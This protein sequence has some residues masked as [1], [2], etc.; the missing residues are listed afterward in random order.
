MQ[1]EASALAREPGGALADTA[2]V[3]DEGASGRGFENPGVKRTQTP[4]PPF[5]V[6]TI[7]KSTPTRSDDQGPCGSAGDDRKVHNR[8][9]VTFRS[10]P[11]N[12]APGA[13]V[14]RP[15]SQLPAGPHCPRF[16]R[17]LTWRYALYKSRIVLE[18]RYATRLKADRPDKRACV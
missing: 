7:V 5:I 17:T 13:I 9:N 15:S 8:H 2:A 18:K 6:C 16:N 3:A 4:N 10:R 14:K 11:G 12:M 1:R